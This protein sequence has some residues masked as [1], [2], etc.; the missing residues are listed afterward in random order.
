MGGGRAETC[1]WAAPAVSY[2][3][4]GPEPPCT[5]S[6]TCGVHLQPVV[7]PVVVEAWKLQNIL[8]LYVLAPFG[9]HFEYDVDKGKTV[10][11]RPNNAE[12]E[13]ELCVRHGR[14]RVGDWC[15][16]VLTTEKRFC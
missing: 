12:R 3:L 2:L 16:V 11:Y 13:A 1:T 6:A 15:A 14:S 8:L 5:T 9:P 7:R 4:R 10:V